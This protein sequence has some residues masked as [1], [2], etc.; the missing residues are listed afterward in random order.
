MSEARITINGIPLAEGEAMTV[1]LALEAF[2]MDLAGEVGETMAYDD[3][4]KRMRASYQA[5][6]T[7]IRRAM[8]R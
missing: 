1:R 4:G 7:S 8:Y 3:L 2:A 6:I 5:S